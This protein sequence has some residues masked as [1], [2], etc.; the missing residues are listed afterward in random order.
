MANNDAYHEGYDAH[1]DGV[2][3]VGTRRDERPRVPKSRGGATWRLGRIATTGIPVRGRRIASDAFLLS[4]RSLVPRHNRPSDAT[5]GILGEGILFTLW[6]R[7]TGTVPPHS[8]CAV[9]R[10]GEI[11]TRLAIRMS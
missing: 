7:A 6:N 11:S 10:M 3:A 5:R 9:S 2:G 4:P 8:H 1:W